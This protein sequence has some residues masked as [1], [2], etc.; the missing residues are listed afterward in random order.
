MQSENLLEKIQ[1]PEI[2]AQA[3]KRETARVPREPSQNSPRK[4]TD[5]DSSRI[6]AITRKY[7]T[8]GMV[9]IFVVKKGERQ[10][11]LEKND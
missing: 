4:R 11:E 1:L 9:H 10:R 8:E 2:G 6:L 3:A 5:T 7:G